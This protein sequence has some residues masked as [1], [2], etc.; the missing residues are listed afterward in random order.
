MCFESVSIGTFDFRDLA[1]AAPHANP[2]SLAN[3]KRLFLLPDLVRYVLLYE[4]CHTVH[5]N[6]PR[7]FG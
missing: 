6:H 2:Q 7:E 1:D 5:M 3:T 4:L